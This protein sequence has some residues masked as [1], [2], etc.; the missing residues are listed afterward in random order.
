MG[1]IDNIRS[2]RNKLWGMTWS[3]VL[4]VEK[5]NTTF[6]IFHDNASRKYSYYLLISMGD[7]YHLLYYSKMTYGHSMQLLNRKSLDC[8][9]ILTGNG[10]C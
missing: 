5:I 8:Q 6:S 1:N 3:L 7:R 10:K 9:F 2:R 4:L